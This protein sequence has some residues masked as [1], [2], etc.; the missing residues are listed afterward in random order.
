MVQPAEELGRGA[1]HGLYRPQEG[2][3]HSM[4]H[5]AAPGDP[6]GSCQ[7][8][9]PLQSPCEGSQA[10]LELTLI[11]KLRISMPMRPTSGAAT[12]RTSLANWSRSW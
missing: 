3:K 7:A 1:G 11:V 6:Q 4:C 9:Q 8:Q 10:P 12:S 2:S 5:V